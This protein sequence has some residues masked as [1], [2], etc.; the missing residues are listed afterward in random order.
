MESNSKIARPYAMAAFQQADEEGRIAEWAE[1]LDLL[2]MVVSDPVTTGLMSNPRVSTQQLA[3]LV[4]DVCG[5]ALSQTGQNFVRILCE[6]RRLNVMQDIAQ[7]YHVA[8]ARQEKRSDVLV[9][10]AFELSPAQQSDIT[11]AMTRRL[12]TRVDLRVEIDPSLIGGVIIRAGDTVVDASLR[13]RLVQLAQS[14]V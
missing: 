5:D 14:V 10:S 13:G 12:G 3:E 4:L 6:N 8:R 1:M 7:A 9:T 2:V 11:V